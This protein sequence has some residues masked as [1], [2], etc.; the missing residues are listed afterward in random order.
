MTYMVGRILLVVGTRP[1]AIKMVPVYQALKKRGA[2]VFLCATN[3]HTSLLE[4][5]F[6]VFGVAA[7]I[8]LDIM[9]PGQDLFYITQAILEKMRN[10]I[11]EY[12]PALLA[13]HGDTTTAFAAALSAFYKKV[14]VAHI[15]AGLRSGDIFAP[16]P[17]EMNRKCITQMA[18]YHF[19]P[20]AFNVG[21]L[22]S[23]GVARD[24]V[25]CTGNTV[26]DAL[27]Y[28]QANIE[29]HPDLVDRALVER[30]TQCK[31]K[32]H[33]VMLLTAHRRESL[34]G[35]IV[36]ALRAIAQFLDQ[37]ADLNALFPV[38]PN[39]RVMEAVCQAG[40][41]KHAQIMLVPALSYRDLVYVL[42]QV[43]WVVTDSGGLQEEAVSLGRPVLVL[44]DVS[45]RAECFWEGFGRLVGTS[46]D[47]I[48]SGLQD[49]YDGVML[50]KTASAIYGD[51]KASVRIAEIMYSL[52]GGE[53]NK[54]I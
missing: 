45:E 48:I 33:R 40:L 1:E 21:Q 22:F 34:D 4:Q 37:H 14:P 2:Q 24:R 43:D 27:H 11:E 18:S 54:S 12:N 53:R 28:V 10:V 32:G 13:V 3:Q 50:K 29:Q 20:T 36:N 5:V 25:Y 23:E 17:E 39:P 31:K 15:E 35:D 9:K 16:Y 30:I 49:C 47:L 6:T 52:L 26:V 7:D 8:K 19:A 38:H 41:D 44:R 42:S 51:G 46:G